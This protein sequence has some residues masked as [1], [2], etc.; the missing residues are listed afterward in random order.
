MAEKYSTVLMSLQYFSFIHSPIDGH[1]GCFH[2]LAIVN[3][4]AMTIGVHVSFLIMVFSGYLP[5]SGIA[6]L[7]NSSIFSFIMNVPSVFHS[8]GTNLHSHQLCR[9][10]TFSLHLLQHLLFVDFFTV[11]ILTSVK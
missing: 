1:L 5:R 10:V 4:V 9:R 11:V 7:D 8:G 3:T 2:V 6:R